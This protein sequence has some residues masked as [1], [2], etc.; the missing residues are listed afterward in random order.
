MSGHGGPGYGDVMVVGQMPA[1]GLRAG[2]QALA[3]QFLAEPHEQ[4]HDLGW[5]CVRV[6]LGAA[7]AGFE[8]GLALTSVAGQELVEPRG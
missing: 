1:D 8:D 5:G 6:C 3:G 4:V 2:V 7:G